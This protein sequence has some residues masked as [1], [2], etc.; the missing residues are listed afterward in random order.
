MTESTSK[1]K[2]TARKAANEIVDRWLVRSAILGGIVG[3]LGYLLG[4]SFWEAP[5]LGVVLADL[6]DTL[7]KTIRLYSFN[8]DIPHYN[9]SLETREQVSIVLLHIA[10]YLSP[11]TLYGVLARYL[12][13]ITRP[14]RQRRRLARLTGHSIFCGFTGTARVLVDGLLAAH[15]DEAKRVVVIENRALD[16]ARVAATR[17]GIELIESTAGQ[18]GVLA[19]ARVEDAARLVI[20]TGNDSLNLAIAA[21]LPAALKDRTSTR[22]LEA[23]IEIS[24]D[25]LLKELIDRD[26]FLKPTETLE[27]RPFHLPALVASQYFEQHNL[28]ADA[29]LRGQDRVHLVLVGFDPT[30]LQIVLQLARIC[31]TLGLARPAVTVMTNQPAR[32][33]QTLEASYAEVVPES[34]TQGEA[35]L[36]DLA[37]LDWSPDL[38]A[39]PAILLEQIEARGE[40]TAIVVSLGDDAANA[41]AALML[42][43]S[44]QREARWRAPIHVHQTSAGSFARFVHP[45]S[46]AR[47]FADIIE[48]FGLLAD[49]CRLDA[50]EGANDEAARRLHNGYLARRGIA[51]DRPL[52]DRAANEMPWSKLD[53]GYRRA[54]RR[55]ADHLPVKL[56]SLGYRVTGHPLATPAGEALALSPAEADALARLEH[57]AWSH[58]RRL[59]GWRYGPLRDNSRRFHDS[60]VPFDRLSPEIQGLDHEHVRVALGE[61]VRRTDLAQATVF[62]DHRVGLLGGDGL[63]PSDAAALGPRLSEATGKALGAVPAED[64]LSLITLLDSEA[65]IRL[66][67]AAA[68]HLHARGR[69]RFLILEAV[70]AARWR[71]ERRARLA[72]PEAHLEDLARRRDALLA[73]QETDW[74]LDF[75]PPAVRLED[76]ERA[77]ELA[78]EARARALA[79]MERHCQR[80]LAVDRAGPPEFLTRWQQRQG[81]SSALHLIPRP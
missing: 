72:V 7:Y 69:W 17:L 14:H 61:L 73:R 21:L 59:A 80:L 8:S 67:E 66:A 33:R 31:P 64:W 20:A 13:R 9:Q 56:A 2:S 70:P 49:I 60:L 63:T 11:V 54:N 50:L 4:A 44:A 22:P 48:P 5:R 40:I 16:L 47:R 36:I 76:W 41:R 78:V 1:K 34:A 29:L 6:S 18:A 42:R 30:S 24:D 12:L 26:A 46:E 75:T 81:P 37:I 62:R 10:R 77:P 39:P 57:E 23:H 79:Y 45:T 25:A 52:T 35:S 38:G 71:A 65:E 15:P 19:Q 68:G 58:E 53:E 27:L 32:C 28:M 43:T 74:I 51:P 3:F 55:S